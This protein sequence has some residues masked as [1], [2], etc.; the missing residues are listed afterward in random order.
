MARAP[1][2]SPCVNSALVHDDNAPPI[3]SV[4]LQQGVDAP[5]VRRMACTFKTHGDYAIPPCLIAAIRQSCWM[6]RVSAQLRRG[7]CGRI[8]RTTSGCAPVGCRQPVRRAST[9]LHLGLASPVA[10]GRSAR[11]PGPSPPRTSPGL[12]EPVVCW[13]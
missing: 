10:S 13:R 12:L 7:R 9:R 8:L 5:C 4:D 1:S 11:R 6:L 2:K 3:F